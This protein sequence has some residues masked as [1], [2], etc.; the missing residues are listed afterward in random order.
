VV[1][2]NK[3]YASTK[4]NDNWTKEKRQLNRRERGLSES[5]VRASFPAYPIRLFSWNELDGIRYFS[6]YAL[7]TR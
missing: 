6:A 7:I 2:R 3:N 5:L 1:E 4:S